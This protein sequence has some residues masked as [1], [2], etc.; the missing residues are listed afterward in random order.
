[1]APGGTVVVVGNG[2]FVPPLV[3]G[4]I[5]GNA[6]DE[7][8]VVVDIPAAPDVVEKRG[9]PPFPLV[10]DGFVGSFGIVEVVGVPPYCGMVD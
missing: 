8:A 1:M 10:D 3:V 9:F 4:G 5:V 6:T 2:I 7:G